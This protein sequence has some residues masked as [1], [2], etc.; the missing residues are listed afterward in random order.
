VK[1]CASSLHVQLSAIALLQ[2]YLEAEASFFFFLFSG[3]VV[4]PVPVSAMP[5]PNRVRHNG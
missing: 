5:G 3:G 2:H 4:F 1:A